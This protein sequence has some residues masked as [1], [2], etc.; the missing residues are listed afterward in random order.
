MITIIGISG[1]LKHGKTE[2]AKIL[3]TL[4]PNA[5]IIN[6]ADALKEEVSKATGTPIETIEKN[7]DTFRTILQWWGTDFRRAKNHT[8]WIE[9]WIKRCLRKI[10]ETNCE[11]IIVGDVRFLNEADAIKSNCGFVWRVTRP[12]VIGTS[13]HISEN[14]M[15]TYVA[16]Y[17]IMNNGTVD[18][19]RSFLKQAIQTI[20]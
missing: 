12:S 19:L 6:F 1:H 10:N 16:D 7:K 5:H 9:E 11:Y 13:T 18:D 3:C 20:K 14:E 8:Y 15:D 4:L 17:S 2:C